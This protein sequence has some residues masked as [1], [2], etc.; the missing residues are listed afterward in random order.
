MSSLVYWK[1]DMVMKI[2]FLAIPCCLMCDLSATRCTVR[3][4]RST[5]ECH[6]R[7]WRRNSSRNWTREAVARERLRATLLWSPSMRTSASVCSPAGR[8]STLL[9]SSCCSSTRCPAK[10]LTPCRLRGKIT[11]KDSADIKNPKGLLKIFGQIMKTSC[12]PDV[13]SFMYHFQGQSPK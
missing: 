9:R 8:S 4:W 12:S 3:L 11:H 7:S 10:A 1:C 2:S 6:R 5:R 13:F